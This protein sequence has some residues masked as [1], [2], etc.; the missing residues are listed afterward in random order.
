MKDWTF[1]QC[2]DF[3]LDREG[4]V[5]NHSADRGGLTKWGITQKT[6]SSF[7][8]RIGGF[9][10]PVTEMTEE[11]MQEI[12]KSLY[13]NTGL[14]GRL[15]VPANL[16]H[17]DACVN[18]GVGRANRLLQETL[19]VNADGI[20]GSKT[21]A[22]MGGLDPRLLALQYIDTRRDFYD[23]IVASDSSQAVFL[24]GWKNRMNHLQEAID[25]DAT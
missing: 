5:S 10:R 4:G 19:G 23:A 7:K 17:F 18:H 22:A 15:P 20:L 1:E 24:K 2:L 8:R 13:W 16:V 3:V 6:Y 14:C 25:A 11:E 21:F 12:Y 9:E